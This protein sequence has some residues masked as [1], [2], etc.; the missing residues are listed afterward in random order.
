[1]TVTGWAIVHP[2][3]WVELDYFDVVRWTSKLGV[4]V[5]RAAWQRQFRPRCRIV[6]V[7]VTIPPAKQPRTELR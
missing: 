6:R 4:R 7:T 3:G 5:S 2:A 1:M